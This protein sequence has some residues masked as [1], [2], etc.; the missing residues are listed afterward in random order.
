MATR[1]ETKECV[2]SFYIE[3]V[4]LLAVNF[5]GFGI[6]FDGVTGNYKK[7]DTIKVK[8]SGKIGS[9]NFKIELLVENEED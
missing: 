4:G 7:G 2:V 9:K 5:D 6:A 8:Y 1:T 3:R